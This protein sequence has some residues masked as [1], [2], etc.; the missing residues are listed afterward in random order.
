MYY[1]DKKIVI[2]FYIGIRVF[3]TLKSSRL[4]QGIFV[5]LLF[6]LKLLQSYFYTDAFSQHFYNRIKMNFFFIY[7]YTKYITPNIMLSLHYISCSI[8]RLTILS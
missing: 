4:Y 5:N 8:L 1:H 2:T 3:N 6:F 7:E